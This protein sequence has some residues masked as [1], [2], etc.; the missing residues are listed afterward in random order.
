MGIVPS[1]RCEAS[2]RAIG[3]GEESRSILE[4]VR[5]GSVCCVHLVQTDRQGA[6]WEERGEADDVEGGAGEKSV[7][8]TQRLGVGRASERGGGRGMVSRAALPKCS[9]LDRRIVWGLLLWHRQ[10]YPEHEQY[11]YCYW[12]EDI[13]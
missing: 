12:L 10:H 11:E 3:R 6:G 4:L 9:I 2:R 5:H 7:G 13:L 8:L 1:A